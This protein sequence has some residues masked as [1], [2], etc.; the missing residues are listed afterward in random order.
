MKCL[1]LC[2]NSLKLMEIGRSRMLRW[3]IWRCGGISK[4]TAPRT[5]W[6]VLSKMG[7][8][9]S[10]MGVYL[11]L[12]KPAPIMMI[13]WTTS[14][15]V[16]GLWLKSWRQSSQASAGRLI[17]LA[18][19]KAMQ[20]LLRIW[21]LIPCFSVGSI[22]KR[23]RN[24]CKTKQ[25]WKSGELRKRILEQTKTFCRWSWRKSKVS[26]AGLRASGSTIIT[27]KK[28]YLKKIAAITS[29]TPTRKWSIWDHLSRD[30]LILMKMTMC[31]W[32]SAVISPSPT[33]RLIISF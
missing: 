25:G 13:Y 11:H 3:S 15:V 21:A 27:M 29:I 24:F 5:R 10:S 28:L 9:T 4:K 23:N 16:T 33:P 14:W 7:S 20:G 18:F 30:S 22:P 8:S 32:P 31:T 19:Q 12:M 1:I 17:H 26:I 2:F 6:G